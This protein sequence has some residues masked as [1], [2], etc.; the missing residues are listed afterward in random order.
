[1]LFIN[2]IFSVSVKSFLVYHL[3]QT[4]KVSRRL[5]FNLSD[6]PSITKRGSIC[7]SYKDP[8]A[9]RLINITSLTEYLVC[10]VGIHMKKYIYFC[11]L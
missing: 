3:N 4:P 6:H 11:C 10:E 5:Q 2:I 9:V 1:M 7:I 8:S